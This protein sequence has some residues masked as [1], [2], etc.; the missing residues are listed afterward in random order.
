MET[1]A[2]FLVSQSWTRPH[3]LCSLHG[4]A[5]SY[6]TNE[7]QCM[8]DIEPGDT[9][10]LHSISLLSC[11]LCCM[12]L[13]TIGDW[14]FLVAVAHT[15]NGLPQHVISTP[16]LVCFPKSPQGFPF[17]AFLPK[18]FHHNICKQV[19]KISIYTAHQYQKQPLTHCCTAYTVV[20]LG[21]LNSSF[22]LLTYLL[23]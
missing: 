12:Q 11:W 6:L 4:T 2:N 9:F 10:T 22:Y 1:E 18:D 7:L 8:A 13:C 14:A 23:T 19:S 20:I 16:S 21:H 17:Q 5:P 15:W 3:S